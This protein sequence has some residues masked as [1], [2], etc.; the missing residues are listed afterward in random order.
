MTET[1]F[2][3]RPKDLPDFENPPLNEV[4]FGIQFERPK[5]YHELFA[6]EIW[7]RLFDSSKVPAIVE[8]SPPSF[9]TFGSKFKDTRRNEIK[10]EHLRPPFE[11]R[12]A[13][14]T[15][16]GA[17][18]TYFQPDKVVK[19]WKKKDGNT[20][21]RYE[22]IRD[23][24]VA[25]VEGLRKL[26]SEFEVGDIVPT[27]CELVYANFVKTDSLPEA[28]SL[29]GVNT[30]EDGIEIEGYSS[31]FSK[32]LESSEGERW[33]RLHG[34]FWSTYDPDGDEALQLNLLVRGAPSEPTVDD[35]WKFFHRARI[36]IV[37][38]FDQLCKEDRKRPWKKIK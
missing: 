31:G 34:N 12:Y 7:R 27:Q 22:A 1:K 25:V 19:I 5:H 10:F 24:F 16:D 17:S 30:F 23:D 37:R 11:N 21:P 36:E 35:C 26:L 4:A 28:L 18:V 13:F 6:S 2:P 9:E 20:Y 33:G 14:E 15:D 8:K 3:D 32:I 29:F 38:T